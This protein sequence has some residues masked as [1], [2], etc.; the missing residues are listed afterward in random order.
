[1]ALHPLDN[2]TVLDQYAAVPFPPGT[3]TD[4]RVFYSPVDDIHGALVHVLASARRSV[5]LAMY[6]FDDDDLA[7]IITRKL[8]DEKVYVQLTLDSSQAGG[9]HERAILSREHYPASTIAIGRSERGAIMHL[10]EV[11]VDGVVLVTGSTNWSGG[12]ETKQDNQLTVELNPLGLG[13]GH[14]PARRYPRQHAGE[15]VPFAFMSDVPPVPDPTPTPIIPQPR[16]APA[17]T[18]TD[19]LYIADVPVAIPTAPV[20][21]SQWTPASIATYVLAFAVF[22]VGVLT[23]YGVIPTGASD[24]V[25]AGIGVAQTLVGA[26]I[27]LFALVSKNKTTR[28]AI[29]AGIDPAIAKRL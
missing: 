17:G 6:G 7:G 27:P 14:G 19:P 21:P 15:G 22:T 23:A 3:P 24:K 9:V 13:G 28:V 5:V 29:Q 10:K 2:L 8:Q 25:A 26:L 4:R 11:V 1:M 20:L 12:G 18:Y 16:H